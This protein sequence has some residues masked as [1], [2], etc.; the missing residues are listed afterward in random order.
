MKQIHELNDI[1]DQFNQ[2]ISPKV[3]F[4]F[5][6]DGNTII[7]LKNPDDN[8]FYLY[9]PLKYAENPFNFLIHAD[10]NCDS[11]RNSLSED[12]YNIKLFRCIENKLFQ[13]IESLSNDFSHTFLNML[14]LKSHEIRFKN[15]VDG[16]PEKISKFVRNNIKLEDNF[17]NII[18]DGVPHVVDKAT[19]DF[20]VNDND[21]IKSIS[22]N[23]INFE[24]HELSTKYLVEWGIA[25]DFDVEKLIDNFEKID[26]SNR[27]NDWFIKLFYYLKLKLENKSVSKKEI[28]KL[29]I[30]K[31]S[32]GIFRSLL[33]D[34]NVVQFFFY[35]DDEKILK[36]EDFRHFKRDLIFLNVELYR[37]DGLNNFFEELGV[38][39]FGKESIIEYIINVI[40]NLQPDDLNEEEMLFY[41]TYLFKNKDKINDN[42]SLWLTFRSLCRSGKILLKIKNGGWYAPNEIYFSREYFSKTKPS[43]YLEDI[44]SPIGCHFLDPIY[45]KKLNNG[46]KNSLDEII[47]WFSELNVENKPRMIPKYHT[48]AEKQ[49]EYEKMYEDEISFEMI[50]LQDDNDWLTTP[51]C[52][53]DSIHYEN[54][55]DLDLFVKRNI[56]NKGKLAK[57]LILLLNGMWDKKW[58][59][60]T[61]SGNYW[62]AQSSSYPFDMQVEGTSLLSSL[63]T[64]EWVPS[65][66]NDKLLK[67][68]DVFYSNGSELISGQP[69]LNL[70]GLKNQDFIDTF[71]KK[72]DQET[73]INQIETLK[74]SNDGFDTKLEQLCNLLK[75]LQ[76][77]K[78]SDLTENELKTKEIILI[79]QAGEKWYP[80]NKVA[81]DYKPNDM[82]I[83]GNRGCISDK[84]KKHELGKFFT[85]L[86]MLQEGKIGIEHYLERLV[87]LQNY[88]EEG[89]DENEFKN[90]RNFIYKSIEQLIA[91]TDAL[92]EMDNSIEKFKNEGCIYCEDS[93]FHKF[94]D[95]LFFIKQYSRAHDLFSKYSPNFKKHVI[96]A[97][98]EEYK[99]LIDKLELPLLD[100]S[101]EKTLSEEIPSKRCVESELFNLDK[102][103]KYLLAV[104]NSSSHNN[105]LV[106]DYTNLLKNLSV[107]CAEK[108]RVKHSIKGTDVYFIGSC[109]HFYYNLEECILIK[110]NTSTNKK[111][112]TI[113]KGL[114][115]LFEI[116]YMVASLFERII[117]SSDKA[118]KI[119]TYLIDH[120][121]KLL[122]HLPKSD[123]VP[124]DT[125]EGE[126]VADKESDE[127]DGKITG[128]SSKRTVPHG[129]SSKH[130]QP[131]G[132]S[133][134]PTKK[135]VVDIPDDSKYDGDNFTNYDIFLGE[136]EFEVYEEP[137][138]VP[139]KRDNLS[140]KEYN[141]IK[142]N[143]VDSGSDRKISSSDTMK[144]IGMGG[145]QIVVRYLKDKYNDSMKIHWENENGEGKKPY[146]ILITK[147]GDDEY[148]EVKSTVQ[149]VNS[150]FYFSRK[151]FEKAKE[152]GDKYHIYRVYKDGDKI[153]IKD[154]VNPYRMMMDGGI[155]IEKFNIKI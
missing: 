45:I 73:L 120:D 39:T 99:N 35:P 10:F 38:N 141:G 135:V 51:T 128:E 107:Q 150:I 64:A 71:F 25:S 100:N 142:I 16:A 18:E 33:N 44:F 90:H 61:L 27:L 67:P 59:E 127:T 122:E 76:S 21:L 112:L 48:S 108:I 110:D 155:T 126:G 125:G 149:N 85:D 20:L 14:P 103:S 115:D 119:E 95:G 70:D 109:E 55:V 91:K 81:W 123:E 68:K 78:R 41:T 101:I 8:K 53:I 47:N 83:F 34:S 36:S 43:Y 137:D 19:I 134:V 3:I 7:P 89:L 105:K 94:T 144:D 63:L 4:A 57:K 87:E 15:F 154:I 26:L 104:V 97:N 40:N 23:L 79:D 77:V 152:K 13:T 31:D 147:N 46:E 88:K 6:L 145:E 12:D 140:T 113:S 93:E 124:S 72:H 1:K 118:D 86:G 114:C 30:Y 56:K 37:E 28:G 146:D 49:T 22:E 98:Y 136:I 58:N 129:I 117:E 121:I 50:G 69:Y 52:Q 133:D 82:N 96:D 11:S 5:S 132:K 60:T 153:K 148:I 75:Y 102:I 130:V 74:I 116:D 143:G 62:T 66:N 65:I 151:Q 106:E 29:A 139:A 2:S 131:G 42:I 54:S 92:D 84:Y 80:I 32:K 24:L 9:M 17:K 138:A 111:I